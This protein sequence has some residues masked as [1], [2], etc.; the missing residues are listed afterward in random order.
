MD[1]TTYTTCVSISMSWSLYKV[2]ECRENMLAKSKPCGRASTIRR[3]CKVQLAIELYLRERRPPRYTA[4]TRSSASLGSHYPV[5]R[6]QSRLA[7]F[8]I[9]CLTHGMDL[10]RNNITTNVRRKAYAKVYE[11]GLTGNHGLNTAYSPQIYLVKLHSD[12]IQF[13]LCEG[14][15][16]LLGCT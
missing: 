14:S 16:H 11:S 12:I 13:F 15:C 8:C 2:L 9:A 1:T 3:C 6:Q 10:T 5:Y 7:I 4:H